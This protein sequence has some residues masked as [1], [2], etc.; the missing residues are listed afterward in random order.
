MKKRQFKQKLNFTKVSI[1]D[2]S[3]VNGGRAQGTHYD[4]CDPD[5]TKFPCEIEENK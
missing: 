2:L 4:H 3:T 5:N 1:Y